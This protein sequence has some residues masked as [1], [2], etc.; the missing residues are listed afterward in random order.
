ML[1]FP[2]ICAQPT[3]KQ[4]KLFLSLLLGSY[5][6]FT[7]LPAFSQDGDEQDNFDIEA[8]LDMAP[9]EDDLD[10]EGV[11]LD[12]Q[13]NEGG[14]DPLLLEDL[15]LPT[16]VENQPDEMMLEEP[17]GVS[18]APA[19]SSLE[20]T[21]K[22]L[23]ELPSLK[24]EKD[25]EEDEEDLFFDSEAL[26]PSGEMGKKGPPRKLNPKTEPASTLV[27]VRKNYAAGSRQAKMVAADRAVQLG[28][29]DSAL[30]LYDE[31][32]V[33]YKRDPN[34]LLG[35]AIALQKVNRSESAIRA[36]EELLEIKPDNVEAQVNMLGLLGQRYPEVALRRLLVLLDNNPD[37]EGIFAQLAFLQANLG[38]Y[39]EALE[40]F[41]RVSA[42]E[43]Q[44]A[45]YVYNMAIVSD[46]AGKK[47]QAIQYYEQSL[48][49]DTVYGGGRSIPREAVFERL[50]RL[51]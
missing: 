4:S 28:R 9:S 8:T 37:H 27:V 34:V 48:E 44:N 39:D 42:M 18:V 2:C 21:E 17:V 41:G 51:R 33:K 38:R 49:L 36:Y 24:E 14:E 12:F 23:L 20:E 5:L 10:I 16:P 32:Y 15:P 45:S 19:N 46:K 31:L 35:R 7:S 40:Y 47:K 1:S 11:D 26:V 13:I 43:P 30:A 6:Y 29:Y 50:A 25:I 22:P 3:V